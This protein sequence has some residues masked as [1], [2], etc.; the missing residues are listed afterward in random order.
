VHEQNHS[1]DDINQH[2]LEIRESASANTNKVKEITNETKELNALAERL[3]QLI[4][5]YHR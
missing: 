3:D 5:Q 1:I 2:M 4:A